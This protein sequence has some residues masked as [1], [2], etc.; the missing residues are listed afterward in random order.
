V[1]YENAQWRFDGRLSVD[2]AT[3][4]FQEPDDTIINHT[5]VVR[6]LDFIDLK[7]SWTSG[8]V[9]LRR[10]DRRWSA[11][12][13]FTLDAKRHRHLWGFNNARDWFTRHTPEGYDSLETQN[14]GGA[15]AEAAFLGGSRWSLTAG[16]H[17]SLLDGTTYFAPR[18]AAGAQLSETIHLE[19]AADRRHQFAAITEEPREG[20]ITQ[21]VFLLER[22]RIADMVALA[23]I[24]R[25]ASSA[26]GQRRGGVEVALYARRFRDR[27]VLDTAGIAIRGFV[28]PDTSLPQLPF[29]RFLRVPGHALG[30]SVAAD[31]AWGNRAL[32]QGNYTAQFV[33]ERAD[34]GV[35][36]TDWD[37]PHSL[38]LF[39]AAPLGKG[40]TL[41]SAGQFRS[42]TAVTSIVAWSYEPRGSTFSGR[43]IWSQPN[44]GRLQAYHRI[45]LGARKAWKSN[46]T[47]WALSFQ[48]LNLLY[49]RPPLEY[50]GD[51]KGLPIVPSIGLEARW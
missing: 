4:R 45:D 40:W 49:K 48:V 6:V 46:R 16:G 51:R 23:G 17:A 33:R 20:S 19:V 8:S 15:F 3:V 2:R 35:R 18:L 1:R 34:S 38:N 39:A 21:P 11:S 10:V 50:F 30:A 41:T 44:G 14:I 32:I 26:Q 9:E 22:P 29:P 25:P 36:P 13:G 27:T 43:A 5:Q 28:S 47:D 7:Q 31:I 42:G 12:G 24:W 37:A